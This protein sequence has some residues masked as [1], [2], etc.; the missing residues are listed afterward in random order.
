[1]NN[2]VMTG[3]DVELMYAVAKTLGLTVKKAT[4]HL[5]AFSRHR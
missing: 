1:M 2:G 4:L 3:F 5:K